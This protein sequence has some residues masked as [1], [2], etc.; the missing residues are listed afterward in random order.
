[1]EVTSVD[2]GNEITYQPEVEEQNTDIQ[3]EI[4]LLNQEFDLETFASDRRVPNYYAFTLRADLQERVNF[5][6][7]QQQQNDLNGFS[8]QTPVPIR[9]QPNDTQQTVLQ[10]AYLAFAQQAG[11]STYAQAQFVQMRDAADDNLIHHTG[12]QSTPF[13]TQEFD[14]LRQTGGTINM[15]PTA[16]DQRILREL[17]ANDLT[18]AEQ[19][20]ADRY[21][22]VGQAIADA[23]RA[24]AS[25]PADLRATNDPSKLADFIDRNYQTLIAP[26][27]AQ[28]LNLRGDESRQLS[29]ASL[30]NEIG[31][32]MNLR[33]N[34]VPQTEQDIAALN[35][36]TWEFYT[37][38]ERQAIQPILDSIRSV[39]GDSPRV[40]SLP[41]MFDSP[42]T[43]LVQVPLFRVDTPQGERFVDNVG[44]V[45]QNFQDWIDNNKLPSGRVS[46]PVNGH[47]TADSNGRAQIKTEDTD[48][49]WESIRPWVDG[50]VAVLGVV[51]GV[52]AIIGTG[53]LATPIVLGGAAAYGVAR[54]GGELYDR[55]SHNQSISPFDPGARSEWINLGANVVGLAALGSSL[56]VAS[57]VS[58]GLTAS[59]SAVRLA[60]GLNVASQYADTFAMADTGLTLAANWDRMTPQE[61]MMAMGQIA[62]WGGMQAHSIRQAGGVSNLYG[63]QNLDSYMA[64][65]RQQ[66]SN[67][68]PRLYEIR[69][70]TTPDGQTMSVVVRKDLDPNSPL[71]MS[72]VNPTGGTTPTRAPITAANVGSVTVPGVRNGEFAAWFNT[73]TK[74]EMDVLWSNPRLRD[75]I[76]TRLR[77]PGG[78]HEWLMV[79]RTPKFREWG[80]T[81]EQIWSMR[82]RT[83]DVKFSDP[84]GGSHGHD[85]S[86][87]FH[88]ELMRIIDTSNS[89]EEFR[90][91]LQDLAN[92]RL[93]G[94]AAA[95][96]EG[97]RP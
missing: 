21:T 89:F 62:F 17:K 53:G 35:A 86:G 42:E 91:K 26:T 76:E 68:D 74:A 27:F 24:W 73:L 55:A 79:S 13:T 82:N 87:T 90:T 93:E 51:A 80:I 11:L 50:G 72:N 59:N 4:N 32:A 22:R 37:G 40:A 2:S 10:R 28:Y 33:P 75:Q 6:A 30:V 20:E 58:R 64:Q 84:Q 60:T 31:L 57:A 45:Y 9:V 34:H 56:R 71:Q 38:A 95:L 8:E 65:A 94:G 67:L 85:G 29:G 1:M 88:N 78:F 23:Q 63:L 83:R 97:L 39:G 25:L 48:T 47:L 14:R 7:P 70:V 18:P 54:S 92:R 19:A 3:V 61:R 44:R 15:Y 77:H 5:V 12:G 69:Q 96:P 41:V 46:Y 43:G 16:T 81:A 49:F 66:L 36:G 52:A